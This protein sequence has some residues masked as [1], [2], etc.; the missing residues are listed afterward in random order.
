VNLGD[1]RTPL[2]FEY[3]GERLLAKEWDRMQWGE[4]GPG[5]LTK[6]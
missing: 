6:R 2:V 1:G 4:E 5:T 3:H